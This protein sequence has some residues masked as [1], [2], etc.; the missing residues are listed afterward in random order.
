MKNISAKEI[1]YKR[2]DKMNDNYHLIYRAP[3]EN[4]LIACKHI[5]SFTFLSIAGL[6]L[7]KFFRDENLYSPDILLQPF[8][9]IYIDNNEIYGFF[10]GFLVIS[11]LLRVMIQRYPLRI[12]KCKNR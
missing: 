1:K 5:T 7:V 4:Y 8:K 10:V 6:A 12:Y 11:V 3:M 9:H 2:T